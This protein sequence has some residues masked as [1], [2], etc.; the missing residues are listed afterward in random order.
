[1]SKGRQ[2]QCISIGK[3]DQPN[4]FFLMYIFNFSLLFSADMKDPLEKFA[5]SPGFGISN[6]ADTKAWLFSK[7]P[8][9]LKPFAD[10]IR[11]SQSFVDKVSDCTT[12][13]VL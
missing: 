3:S 11:R 9:D 12:A 2:L 5:N 7:Y 13:F 10:V 6:A 8:A 4:H 1:M